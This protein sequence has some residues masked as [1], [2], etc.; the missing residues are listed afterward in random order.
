M[1]TGV[2]TWL[3]ARL[4]GWFTVRCLLFLGGTVALFALILV[5]MDAMF[6]LPESVRTAAPWML[7]GCGLGV[8]LATA[9][10]LADGVLRLGLA[11][12]RG[13]VYESQAPRGDVRLSIPAQLA[14]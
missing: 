1:K 4:A 13:A 6:D 8:I 14:R 7:G 5:M 3:R 11:D 10:V 2:L 12:R 9:L